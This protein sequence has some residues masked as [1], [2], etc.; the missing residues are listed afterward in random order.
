VRLVRARGRIGTNG[1][2]LVQ[3]FDTEA[4]AAEAPPALAKAKRRRGYRGL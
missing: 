4:E 3:V 1:R 2:E